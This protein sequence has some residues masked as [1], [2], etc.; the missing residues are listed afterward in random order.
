MTEL[1][2]LDVFFPKA[3]MQAHSAGTV[4]LASDHWLSTYWPITGP[5]FPTRARLWDKQ[6]ERCV[7]FIWAVGGLRKFMIKRVSYAERRLSLVSLRAKM[8]TVPL[9]LE[10]HRK[11]E[12]WLKLMLKRWTQNMKLGSFQLTCVV[13]VTQW[14]ASTS[15]GWPGRFLS[16]APLVYLWWWCQTAEW[17]SL[18]GRLRLRRCPAGSMQR[19][20]SHSDGRW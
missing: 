18:C 7:W 13:A 5:T 17:G 10:A 6:K 1:T 15:R 8:W 9:S 19:R 3:Q 4:K 14:T 20:Q 16:A 12:S 2:F 11:E